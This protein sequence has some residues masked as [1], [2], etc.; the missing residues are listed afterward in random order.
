LK[1][2]ICL[3]IDGTITAEAFHVPEEVVECFESLHLK[4]WKF[5][6]ST[7]RPY[8]YAERIF[9]NFKFPFYLSLQNGADLLQM[10]E[11]KLISKT[12][13]SA[14]FI[15]D[16]DAIYKEMEEDFLIYSGFEHGDFCY[17]RPQRFSAKALEHLEVIQS[18]VPEDWKGVEEFTFSSNDSFPLIKGLGSKE[19]MEFL[20]EK[21]KPFKEVHATL[22]I[23]PLS[24]RSPA[25]PIYLNLITSEHATKGEIVKKMR[26]LFPEGTHFIAAGDDRNDIPMLEEVDFAIVMKSAPKEMH[27]LADLIAEPAEQM[28]IIKA[29]MKAT[30]ET[31]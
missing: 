9:Q 8:A 25:G 12:H 26:T 15:T 17:Y 27:S 10:P 30:G 14:S 31:S 29:L 21:I 24:R 1:G 16:L 11:K 3:D 28:G 2:C 18:I 6:F 23:D 4:G 20:F 22:I 7:G 5:L 13:L 19:Q